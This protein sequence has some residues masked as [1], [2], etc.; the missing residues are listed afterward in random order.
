MERNYMS[1]TK[2]G[3]FLTSECVLSGPKYEGHNSISTRHVDNFDGGPLTIDC[4]FINYPHNLHT[5][6]HNHDYPV[7]YNFFSANPNDV[8]DFDAEIELTLGEEQE[9]HIIKSPTIVHIP[10]SLLHG[11]VRFTKVNKPLLFIKIALA[12]KI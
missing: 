6:S 8:K 9:K 7:Y 2:Y 1:K 4:V 10:A 12:N 3:K 5:T 11:P